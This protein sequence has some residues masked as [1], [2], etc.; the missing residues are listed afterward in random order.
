MQ[1]DHELKR[2]L[3]VVADGVRTDVLREELDAGNLPALSA[4]CATGGVFEVSTSFPSVT[5]PAYVP[6]IMGRHP[7]NVGIPGLRW[8]DRSRR[9]P[10]ATG[11]SRSYA[12]IDIWHADRDVARDIPTA[13]E[14]ARPSL[15]GMTMLARGASLGN[16]GRSVM[17]CIRAAISH[18]QGDTLGWRSIEGRATEIFMRRFAH[19]RPRF[20]V[21]SITSPD[22]FSH[23]YGNRSSEVRGAIRDLDRAVAKAQSIAKNG[24]WLESL[25]IWMVGDHGHAAVHDHDDLHG[26]LETLN[27]RVLAH[28]K[29]RTRNADIALM[30]GGNAMAHL[31]LDPSSRTRQWW[32]SLEGKYSTLLELLVQR[33]SIDVAAVVL[34]GATVRIL[35]A[36]RG[37]AVV[38]RTVVDGSARWDYVV[39]T[40]DPLE[41]G[42]TLRS[43][44]QCTAWQASMETPYPDSIVQLSSLVTSARSGDIVVSAS[45]GWDLRARYEPVPHLSTHGGLLREQMMVPLVLDEKPERMPMRT[46]DVVPSMLAALG[47]SSDAT[48]DGRSFV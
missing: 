40:G 5:G 25:R 48:F 18:F 34:D 12:G 46:T 41:L 16:V 43:L 44:D 42:G 35:S 37:E 20:S 23:R 19:H 7:A 36:S 31:Y 21:L 39:E 15:A 22:K 17:W 8:F 14:L 30:V 4:L 6:F 3:L 11:S 29:V 2:L 9:L 38:R 33:P 28:P 27:Y 32:P 13:L 47:I 24:G 1:Q 26:W 10:F 45:E